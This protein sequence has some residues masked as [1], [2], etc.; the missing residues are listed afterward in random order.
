[1]SKRK[2]KRINQTS[3]NFV[4]ASRAGRQDLIARIPELTHLKGRIITIVGLGCLGAPS[5]LD[6][7]RCGVGELRIID[8]DIVEA[9]TIMR[10]PFGLKSIGRQKTEVIEEFL[11][12]NYPFT[13]V[14]PFSHRIGAVRL[15]N[16][17]SSDLEVLETALKGTD[18]IYDASAEQGLHDFLTD[19][20]AEL[21]LPY[22]AIWTTFGAWGGTLVRIRPGKTEGCWLCFLNSLN[23]GSIPTPYSDPLGEVQPMGCASPTF[24]GAS[25]DTGTIA[26]GGVRLAVSSLTEQDEN[27]YPS[28]EWDIAVINLRDELGNITVP[29]WNTYKLKKHSACQCEKKP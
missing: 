8:F 13:K 4:R 10:W 12:D 17:L 5:V 1:M 22:I 6:F 18:L 7:A 26:L 9:G 23:D 20:S 29:S 2:R 27:S 21:K 28:I 24:T 3:L 19:L 16:N 25:F 11:N 14:V 15:P